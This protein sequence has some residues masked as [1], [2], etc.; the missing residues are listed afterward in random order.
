M[1]KPFDRNIGF[2]I[3]EIVKGENE[4]INLSDFITQYLDTE[5]TL[6][7]R[8][9][10]D[11]KRIEE[12]ILQKEGLFQER[13]ELKKHCEEKGEFLKL[14]SVLRLHIKEANNLESRNFNSEVNSYVKILAGERMY[15]T[16]RVNSEKNPEYNQTFEMFYF[17]FFFISFI[18][19][20]LKFLNIKNIQKIKKAMF[21]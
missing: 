5:D 3:Y 8:I 1:G 6:N 7:F 11:K 10:L 9:D 13:N 16:A 21:I 2:Q 19:F 15:H 12:L 14:Y 4:K 17:F 18:F 20:I